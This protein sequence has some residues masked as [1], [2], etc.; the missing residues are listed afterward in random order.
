[1][2]NLR[3]YPITFEEAQELLERF[4][5][6]Q[7]GIL[8]EELLCGDPTLAILKWISEQLHRLEDLES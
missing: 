1:M 4:I 5:A 3:E 7:S 2:R 6:F 8:D